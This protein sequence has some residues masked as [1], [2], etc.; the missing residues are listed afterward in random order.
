MHFSLRQFIS[1]IVF[2]GHTSCIMLTLKV[3]LWEFFFFYYNEIQF[4]CETPCLPYASQRF[5]VI[6]M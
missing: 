1:K 4:V 2:R 5:A 6:T 3:T